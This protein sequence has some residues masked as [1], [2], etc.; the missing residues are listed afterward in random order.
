LV[1]VCKLDGIKVDASKTTGI[2]A[3]TS[4]MDLLLMSNI[5]KDSE[6]YWI[7]GA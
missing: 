6:D 4:T 1:N 5:R 7:K 2:Q 3:T